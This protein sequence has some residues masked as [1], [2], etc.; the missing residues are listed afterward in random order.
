MYG[1]AI[2]VHQFPKACYMDNF[3]FKVIKMHPIQLEFCVG[4]SVQDHIHCGAKVIKISSDFFYSK[5]SQ[6]HPG[7][8]SDHR[9]AVC[10]RLL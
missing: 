7:V 1:P 3:H 8:D 6:N 2:K 9:G 5:S 10:V 4:V